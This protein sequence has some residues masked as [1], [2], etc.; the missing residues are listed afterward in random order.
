MSRAFWMSNRPA[1]K[2]VLSILVGRVINTPITH[3]INTTFN[4]PLQS[5]P[6]QVA[7][8]EK[9]LEKAEEYP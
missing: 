2:V 1:Q 9:I 5:V 6:L 7:A 4:Q 8:A 3:L